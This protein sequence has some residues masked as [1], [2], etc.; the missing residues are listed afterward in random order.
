LGRSGGRRGPVAVPEPARPRARGRRD[1]PSAIPALG[2]TRSHR[3]TAPPSAQVGRPEARG[4]L[5]RLATRPQHA[6]PLLPRRAARRHRRGLPHVVRGPPVP[7]RRTPGAVA[8]GSIHRGG[9]V[10]APTAPGG[11]RATAETAEGTLLRRAP[12]R[13][14]RTA[15]RYRP[16]PHDEEL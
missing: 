10:C 15:R 5:P 12:G 9:T 4:P 8:E 3:V 14:G 7:G 2:R 11:P 13:D 6:L 1:R 16:S